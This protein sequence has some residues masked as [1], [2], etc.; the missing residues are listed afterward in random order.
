MRREPSSPHDGKKVN[1]L[2]ELQCDK[3]LRDGA[4]SGRRCYLVRGVG[5]EMNEILLLERPAQNA[6]GPMMDQGSM[7]PMR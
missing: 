1:F 5:V 4:A 7:P 6:K 3:G 2:E